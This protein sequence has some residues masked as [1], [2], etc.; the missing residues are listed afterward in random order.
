MQKLLIPLCTVVVLALVALGCGGSDSS[1]GDV[2]TDAVGTKPAAESP[3]APNREQQPADDS[4]K[5]T[6]S[7]STGGGSPGADERPQK[8]TA[9]K[10]KDDGTE[11]GSPSGKP[12]QGKQ[13]VGDHVQGTSAGS[14]AQQQDSPV[15]EADRTH[16]RTEQEGGGSSPPPGSSG[17]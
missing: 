2:S 7:S 9:T 3:S 8:G 13:P 17:H 16:P 14:A 6:P 5:R 12:S 11:R 1:T 15:T 10:T 4:S